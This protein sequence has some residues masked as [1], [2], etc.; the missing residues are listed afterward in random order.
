MPGIP[1]IDIVAIDQGG[2]QVAFFS[3]DPRQKAPARIDTTEQYDRGEVSKK[4][5]IW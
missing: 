1:V 3:F 4:P 5:L 2:R